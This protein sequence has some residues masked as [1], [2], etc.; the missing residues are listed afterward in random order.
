MMPKKD[1]K[2]SVRRLGYCPVCQQ[3][4]YLENGVVPKHNLPDSMAGRKPGSRRCSGSGRVAKG[5]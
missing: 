4:V 5:R 2:Q 3:V 1:H